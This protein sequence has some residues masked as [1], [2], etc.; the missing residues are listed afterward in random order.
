MCEDEQ[1]LLLRASRHIEA[2]ARS[3]KMKLLT[4]VD[5]SLFACRRGALVL[6]C[7]QARQGA[8]C[9]IL[10]IASEHPPGALA[11]LRPASNDAETD[12]LC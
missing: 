8:A 7:I 12:D 6:R 4:R 1:V 9:M 5:V 11:N 2:L 3:M 10:E